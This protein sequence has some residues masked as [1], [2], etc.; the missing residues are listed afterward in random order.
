MTNKVNV[1]GGL[2]VFQHSL[3]ISTC[4]AILSVVFE[5][6]TIQEVYAFQLIS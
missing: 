6:Q 3:L 4:W 5:A 1:K 2:Q